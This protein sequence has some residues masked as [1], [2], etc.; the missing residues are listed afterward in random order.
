MLP[1]YFQLAPP[2]LKH[3]WITSISSTRIISWTVTG[4]A[5]WQNVEV[6]KCAGI[7]K[8]AAEREGAEFE[9]CRTSVYRRR[10]TMRPE[11]WWRWLWWWWW[12]CCCF[13]TGIGG[14]GGRRRS[15]MMRRE[16]E[17]C[18]SSVGFRG[19]TR[20]RRL[21]SCAVFCLVKHLWLIYGVV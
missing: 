9:I 14:I 17:K 18:L 7:N 5:F 10:S 15:R 8:W 16:G 4:N 3:R 11:T 12:C 13:V 6:E 21:L 20:P 2:V 19:D 1:S